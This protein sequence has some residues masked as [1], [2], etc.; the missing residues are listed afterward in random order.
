[1]VGWEWLDSIMNAR[2]FNFFSLGAFRSK[3]WILPDKQ[4]ESPH[5]YNGRGTLWASCHDKWG[6]SLI[7]YG[8]KGRDNDHGLIS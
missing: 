1:M 6:I 5:R 4:C 7:S 3:P 8:R 2:K